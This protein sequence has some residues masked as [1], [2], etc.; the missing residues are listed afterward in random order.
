MAFVAYAALVLAVFSLVYVALG[1]V[2]TL[3]WRHR[4]PQLPQPTPLPAVSVLKPLCGDEPGLLENLRSFCEQSHDSYEI[5]FGARDANDP[6]LEVARKVAAEYPH[7][8]IRIIPG[9]TRLGENRKI[10]TLINLMPHARYDM[11]VI[12]DSDIRVGPNYL[13]RVVQP[14]MDPTVGIVS[15]TYRGRPAG[16]LWSELGALAIDEWFMPWVVSRHWPHYWQTTTY[17]AC[18]SGSWG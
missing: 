7:R 1:V 17:W 14:L 13:Q 6:A 10:N 4:S 18:G 12:V 2:V 8:A 16:G 11:I 15:C 5:L 3:V 9:A